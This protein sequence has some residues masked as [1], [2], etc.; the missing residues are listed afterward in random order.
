MKTMNEAVTQINTE[1]IRQDFPI[2]QRIVNGRQLVYLDSAATTQ[3][4]RQV[5]DALVDY[6]SRY[7]SNVHRAVHTL[8]AE[9]TDAYDGAREKIARFMGAKQRELVFTKNG[10][11]AANI[12]LHSFVLEKLKPG[13][14]IISTVMEHHSNIVPWQLAQKK[15]IKL[16]FVDI[17][18]DG[19]LKMEQYAELVTDKTKLVTV[20][21]VSNVL[22]TVTPVEKIGKIAHDAGALFMVDAAQSVPH[23]PFDARKIG[24]D[25]ATFSGHKM[26]APTG[27]GCLYGKEELLEG[28]EPF[29]RGS[30]MIKEVKLF[31][32]TWNEIP[33]KFETGTPNIADAIAMGAAVDYLQALGMENVWQHEQMLAAYAL[34]RLGEIKDLVIYGP[35]ERGGVVS[36]NLGDVH[37]HDLA[38]VLDEQ[39][40][41]V[42]SGHHCA[43][44]LMQRLEITAC[45]RASFYIYTTKEE[46]D[47]LADALELARKIFKL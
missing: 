37:S 17:N 12:V 29:L 39:G 32:T 16:K 28:M 11:E 13:D 26:L 9:A 2:L 14:E 21:H 7:N 30:D 15:G 1:K 20:A 38:S 19:A 47:K 45:A 34:K 10:S 40:I 3:K 41:A 8:S 5:I 36:F 6:Y 27:I 42:R 35:Q 4:P 18:V 24:C 31:E 46:I 22:G 44:P 43:M 33:Y 23:M 25:F